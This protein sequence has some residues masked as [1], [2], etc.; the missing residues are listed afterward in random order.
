MKSTNV[1]VALLAA[2]GVCLTIAAQAEAQG[3][4]GTQ[5]T[6]DSRRYL[7]SKDVGA[8]RWAISFN[9]ADRTVTGN[10][11]KTDGSPP[12]FI[13]CSITSESPAADPRQT[14]YT[15]DCL[16]AA[17]CAAAPCTSD[18]WTPIASG[19]TIGGDFLLPEGTQSTFRGSVAPIFSASCALPTCHIG[20]AP[21][22]GLNLDS[23]VAY[24]NIVLKLP[25]HEDEHFL[26]E[27]FDPSSSHL[28]LKILGEEEGARMPLDAPPLPE[29]ETEAIR[30]WILE[31]AADN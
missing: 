15:L 8:E 10:V 25:A 27:P 17:A 26:V 9:L 12:S 13:W 21:A 1:A 20:D 29:A 19:L 4:A 31:G 22:E 30:R 16:G 7:I 2:L 18:G 28:F 6:P 11:F 24:G 23:D 3:G 14:S 5:M